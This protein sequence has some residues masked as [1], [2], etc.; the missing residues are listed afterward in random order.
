AVC[1]E[2]DHTGDPIGDGRAAADRERI[3]LGEVFGT[4]GSL[5]R[6]LADGDGLQLVFLFDFLTFRYDPGW[7]QARIVEFER[8]FP[9][10]AAPTYVLENHDRTRLLN[11]VGG[12][13]RKARVL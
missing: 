3:L 2:F 5:R 11:R 10:P 1:R 4:A 8:A 9:F 6:Y 12:D 13:L 7:L